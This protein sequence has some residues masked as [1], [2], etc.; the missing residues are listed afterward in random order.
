M[1]KNIILLL[2]AASSLVNGR[3]DTKFHAVF[4]LRG[5]PLST[6]DKSVDQALENKE[7]GAMFKLLN[8]GTS[9]G[10]V[11]EGCKTL[12]EAE[13]VFQK[14]SNY[15][16]IIISTDAD[17]DGSAIKLSLVYTFAKMGRFILQ[18]GKLYWIDSPFWEQDGKF[19]YNSDP[20]DPGTGFPVGINPGRHFRRFKGLTI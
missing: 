5:K 18:L 4:P 20:I 16:K 6:C 9:E 3:H 8:L 19:Y 14:Y 15:G 2:S 11:F 7:I 13:L 17:S 10:N 12:E 1:L